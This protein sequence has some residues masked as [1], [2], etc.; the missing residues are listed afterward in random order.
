MPRR[1]KN[2]NN[3]TLKDKTHLEK[4]IAGI[5]DLKKRIL[6]NHALS[7]LLG[8]LNGW[9]LF[10]EKNIWADANLLVTEGVAVQ[11]SSNHTLQINLVRIL[12]MAISGALVYTIIKHYRLNL[13]MMKIQN[14]GIAY[15]TIWN[16]ETKVML[17][18]EII[19]CSIFL[20][21]SLN[22]IISM[23]NNG[24]NVSYTAD[25]I[26]STLILSKSYTLLRMY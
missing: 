8:C 4:I 5:E 16:K 11:V 22:L 1:L 9:L 17:V 25:M 13:Q 6:L 23:T 19:V 21:P 2:L 7:A 26:F 24:G 3:V 10:A 18:L 15:P 14:H 20:P 12:C